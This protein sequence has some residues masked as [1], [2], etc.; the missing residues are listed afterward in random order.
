MLRLPVMGDFDVLVVGAASGA[1]AAALEAHAA[2]RSVLAVSDRTYFG[3]ETAGAMQLWP[4]ERVADP[5]FDAVFRP[6]HDAAPPGPGYAK[7]QLE[8]A[9]LEA[10]IPFLFEC[11]PVSLLENASGAIGGAVLASRT[12]LYAVTARVVVDASRTG[13]VARLAGLPLTASA[14]AGAKSLVVV[15]P[16]PPRDAAFSWESAGAPFEVQVGDAIERQSAYRIRLPSGAASRQP[17][18]L[19]AALAADFEDRAAIHYP[20]MLYSADTWIE[21]PQERLAGVAAE[22]QDDPC[23]LP[24]T[25]Y[26]FQDGRLLVMN[27]LLPLTALGQDALLGLAGQLRLGRKVGRLAAAQVAQVAPAHGPWRLA[28]NQGAAAATGSAASAYQGADTDTRLAGTAARGPGD[29]EVAAARSEVEF[30]PTAMLGRASGDFRFAEPLRRPREGDRTLEVEVADV[31]AL[32]ECDVLV[33]GG[34]TAGAPA[35]IAA[36]RSG[37]RTVVLERLHGLGGVGTLGLIAKYWFGNRVGFTAEVDAG[38]AASSADPE[39]ASSQRKSG[40]WNVEEKMG[41]Y[42]RT[43]RDAGG[44]A[45]LHSFAYGVQM[46]GERVVGVLVS[47]PYGAGLVRTGGAIDATG[48]ADLAAAAGAPCRVIDARH[49]AVQGT[50]LSPRRPGAH[51]RNSDHNFI[52]DT[53]LIGTTHAFVHSRA[54][55][56]Q[57]FDV[58]PVVDSRERRQIFGELEL[59]PLDFLAERTYEDTVVT[60]ASNFDSHG[61]T[62]HPVFMIIPPDKKVLKAHV[63]FR[64]LLP[65]GV[66][67]LLVTGLGMSAHRDALPVVRMQA[68]VQNQGYAAGLAAALAVDSGAMLRELD[69]RDLQARLIDV[70]ILDSSVLQHRDSFPLPESEIRAA[71]ARGPVDLY[72]A[73]VILGHPDV[74]IPLLIDVLR[75]TK[76]AQQREDA[77]LILGLFGREEPAETLADLVANR[78]WDEGWN[79]TG[80]GQFGMSMSRLDA[81]IVA[82]GRTRSAIAVEPLARKIDALNEASEFSHCRAVSVAAGILAHRDLAEGL[83]RLAQRPGMLGHAHLETSRVLGSVNESL[84]ETEARNASL[85]E[86]ILA[87]GLYLAGDH[88]GLGRQILETYSNDLRGHYARHAQAILRC[89]DLDALRAEVI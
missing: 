38:V 82:L 61:F 6:E 44:V 75:N 81:L 55:F 87:R 68:D 14:E 33:A 3:E 59:S 26:R 36:A 41:W 51:Y 77:A 40:S 47:T 8:G 85:R 35:G 27:G 22:P 30:G 1:V 25:A 52:D 57:E 10:G 2:G 19:L 23:A 18:D 58:S 34:G 86:L 31:P 7:R 20:G 83:H 15:G 67:R 80:M 39:K 28:A 65:Q 72:T 24:D 49:V 9:L 63:P 42:L 13:I 4:E 32:A 74:S 56:R 64:C 29:S 62:V 60:A 37:A 50:G 89:E 69:L 71:V 76:D 88:N 78:D 66:E 11:R 48:N 45:W 46:E 79:Y 43:L 70:G 12:S 73:S 54:K 16:K 84:T 5:L 53:D 21:A 17:G